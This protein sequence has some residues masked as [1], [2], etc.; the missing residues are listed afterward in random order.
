M[1][2]N[3]NAERDIAWHLIENTGT[4]LFL[5]GKAGTGKT[6]FLHQVVKESKKRLVVL[7][8][9]GIAAINAGGVTIHSFFQFPFSPYVPGTNPT[10]SR[11]MKLSKTK[12]NIIR[13]LDLI[14]IDEVSMVRAD[15][16]DAIDAVLRRVRRI[17]APFG[18]VQLLLIGDLQQLPPV[19]TDA[20]LQILGSYY[21]SFYF[22]ES[23]A[24]RQLRYEMVE[25]RRIY[26]QSE[27]EFIS[28]LNAIREN[29]V[30]AG[31]LRRLN[32]RYIPGFKTPDSPKYI[33]LTTHN[34]L[35]RRVNERELERLPGRLWRNEAKVKGLFPESSFPAD[36]ELQLKEGAQVMFVKNDPSG[37]QRFYNG[38]IGVVEALTPDVV[39]VRPEESD[40][41]LDIKAESWDNTS[42]EIDPETAE[43]KE[44]VDGTFSQFP[45]RLAWAITIHKSQGL[46]FSNAVIDASRSFAHGQCYVALSRCR[47]LEGLVLERPLSAS[48][49]ICDPIVTDFI[50]GCA[51]RAADPS[52]LEDLAGEYRLSLL[53]ELFDFS[54]SRDALADVRHILE[55]AYSSLYPSLMSRWRI[56]EAE[57]TPRM[58]EVGVKFGHQYRSLIAA[59]DTAAFQTRMKAASGYFLNELE[60][61]KTLLAETPRIADNKKL[62]KLIGDRLSVFSDMMGVKHALFKNFK[63]MEF[64]VDSYLKMKAKAMM[65]MEAEAKTARAAVRQ[66]KQEK[67][68]VPVGEGDV[69]NVKLYR[70]LQ[71]WRR[72]KMAELEVP[73]FMIMYTKTLKAI[74]ELQP[75]CIEE[76]CRVPGIGKKKAEDFGAEILEIVSRNI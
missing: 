55:E 15:L 17:N 51:G 5:T 23:H 41:V 33:R 50:R 54:T 25:L 13:S 57:F 7:A 64:S 62:E 75:S 40:M 20:D 63:E 71:I 2:D 29:S 73:A 74:A 1:A 59:G 37:N 9:T 66:Q 60:G 4:S 43:I 11:H 24:F 61:V 31:V 36:S 38:M 34:D 42:Y 49:V 19:V 46:T 16:L 28:L 76:L 39:Y 70:E 8:P 45:L 35:A 21:P 14:I 3:E 18:G 69:S 44:R 56:L 58:S 52:R 26:R 6:T 67:I 68:W 32:S 10:G 30:D 47:S 22:F 27:G 72:A 53:D 65:D 12:L 48:S